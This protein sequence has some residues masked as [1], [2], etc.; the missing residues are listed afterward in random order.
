MKEKIQ[1][2]RSPEYSEVL[3]HQYEYSYVKLLNSHRHKIMYVQMENVQKY[4]KTNESYIQL[5]SKV[6]KL[7]NCFAY[8]YNMKKG[9]MF[10]R[11]YFKLNFQ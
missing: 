5:C 6:G 11:F 8:T 4:S 9:N 2:I 1:N 3:C 7:M 10:A